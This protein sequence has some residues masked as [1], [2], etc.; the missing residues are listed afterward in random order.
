MKISALFFVAGIVGWSGLGIAQTTTAL[1]AEAT[2]MNTLASSQGDSKVV[3]RISSDFS[4]FLGADSK[5]VVT[6]LRNGTPI[7]LTSTD[8]T[9]TTGTTAATTT[10][11]TI[12]NPPTGKMGHGNVFISLALAKQQLGTMGITEPTPQQLQAAL[13]GG[14]ITTTGTTATGTPTTTTTP[15][16]GILTM[17]SQDMGWGQIAHELGYKLGPVISSMK[18]TNQNITTTPSTTATVKANGQVNKSPQ[19][20]I[21]SAGGQSHGNSNHGTSIHKGSGSGIV[22]G[23]GKGSG[24]G[25]AYGNGRG[26]I[27]TGSGHSTSSGG[28]VSAGGN[29]SAHGKGHSK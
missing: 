23:S 2:K 29:G 27:V 11:T 26:S 18:H 12:I 14:S 25:Y 16:K 10:N 7:T 13:T 1:N 28:V 4:S 8:P 6:G 3:D 21:V 22:T 19:T 15:L 24:N 5:T 17:R 9:S 20:G